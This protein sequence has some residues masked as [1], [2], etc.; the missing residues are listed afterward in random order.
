MKKSSL[1]IIVFL[2]LLPLL[3]GGCGETSNDDSRLLQADSMMNQNPDSAKALLEA[4]DARGL[5]SDADVAYHALLLSQARYR[6]YEVAT[7]DSLI[8]VALN[9][10]QSHEGNR[11]RLTRA[12]IYKGAVMQELGQPQIAMTHY[13]RALATVEDDDYFTQG[14]IRL[15]IGNI[16]RDNIVADSTDIMMFKEA[17]HFFKLVP[18]SFYILTCLAEIGS[19]YNKNNPDSVMPY[20]MQADTLARQINALSLLDVNQMFIAEYKMFSKNHEDVEEAKQI[21]LSLLKRHDIIERVQDPLMIASYTLAKQNKTDS[22][23]FYLSQARDL[24]QSPNDSVFYYKCM[25]EAAISQG[26]IRQYQYYFEAADNLS[27]SLV[28]NDLLLKLRD[29]DAKYDNEVLKNDNQ[30]KNTTIA[31]VVL[32]GLL[33]L[34]LLSLAMILIS[35]R[36]AKQRRLLRENEDMIERL[37]DETT[38]LKSQLDGNQ[39]MNESLKSTIR[40]QIDSFAQLVE[41]VRTEFSQDSAKFNRLLKKKYGLKQPDSCFWS[42]L[43]SYVDYTSNDIIKNTKASC[44]ELIDSDLQFL[45]LYCCGLPTTAIMVCMGYND[46]HSVYNK[47]HRVEKIL[48]ADNLDEYILKFKEK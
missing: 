6:C 29:V 36:N 37:H 27:D 32:G 35:H 5:K 24:L 21:A 1:Y 23:R 30:R 45:T 42:G 3:T 8:N 7:S 10:Y 13:K 47:R 41:E 31:L 28:C 40:D 19:S 26:D 2:T 16:Y 22:A 4:I 38:E 25:A 34:S 48:G 43:R 11:E 20:L 9:Y 15:R 44:P 12:L 33:L 14:Y 46:P 39:I 18:D 17:L